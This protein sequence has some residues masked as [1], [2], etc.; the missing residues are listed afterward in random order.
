MRAEKSILTQRE[1]KKQLK[2]EIIIRMSGTIPL[3]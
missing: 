2:D 3:V 1:K